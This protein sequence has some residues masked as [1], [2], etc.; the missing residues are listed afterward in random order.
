MQTLHFTLSF[1]VNFHKINKMFL[2]ILWF[3]SVSVFLPGQEGTQGILRPGGMVCIAPAQLRC[4]GGHN[5]RVTYQIQHG[6]I[7]IVIA[8]GHH[9]RRVNAQHT[10]DALYANPLVGHGGID[11]LGSRHGA[12]G[13]CH[14]GTKRSTNGSTPSTK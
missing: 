11:P 4:S 13:C 1:F 9:I 8:K 6:N 10:A 14:L 5:V 3:C 12:V 2:T 7:I